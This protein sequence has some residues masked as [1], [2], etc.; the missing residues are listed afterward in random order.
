MRDPLFF[1]CAKSLFYKNS[2]DSECNKFV[3]EIFKRS[4]SNFFPT[5]SN[6]DDTK[7]RSIID[8]YL[9]V[10]KDLNQRGILNQNLSQQ[11]DVTKIY[12]SLIIHIEGVIDDYK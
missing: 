10:H 5:I 9:R 12:D 6:V 4:N 1:R 2:H 3:N 8:L 7:F 11:E